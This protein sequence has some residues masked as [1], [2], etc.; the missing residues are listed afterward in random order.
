ML[1]RNNNNVKSSIE[2]SKFVEGILENKT[3]EGIEHNNNYEVNLV[4]SYDEV[5]DVTVCY[6]NRKNKVVRTYS[7]LY[8]LERYSNVIYNYN[9]EYKPIKNAIFIYGINDILSF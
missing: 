1:N 8:F 3:L 6:T 2:K 4:I 5:G 9:L 7:A